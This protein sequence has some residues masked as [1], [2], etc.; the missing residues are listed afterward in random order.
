MLPITQ[1]AFQRALERTFAAQEASYATLA[2]LRKQRHLSKVETA[3]SL[4]MSVDV[5]NKFE[6]GAIELVSLSQRQLERLAHFFQVG[7]D[8]FGNLLENS[9]P[10]IS[11]NRRQNQEAAR[12]PQ[13]GPQHQSFSEAI[14]RSTMSKEDKQFWLE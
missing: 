12:S 2:E 13:Q 14:A 5:W 8:Q 4:R 9:Q 1:R 3:N 7:I 10:A 6:N 11:L